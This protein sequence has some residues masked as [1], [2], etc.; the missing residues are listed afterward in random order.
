MS[1]CP[2]WNCA[3]PGP[4][5][6]VGYRTGYKIHETEKC[7]ERKGGWERNGIKLTD[8][9]KDKHRQTNKYIITKK[10][11]RRERDSQVEIRQKKSLSYTEKD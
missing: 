1:H 6:S 11:R 10:D 2:H 9:H 3:I 5:G 7:S 4:L 8:R